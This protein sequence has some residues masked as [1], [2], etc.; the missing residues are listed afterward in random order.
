MV[1]N[2]EKIAFIHINKT[3]GS[4]IET[5]LGRN[6]D[7]PTHSMLSNLKDIKGIDNYYK[8]SFV[9]NPYDKMVSQYF[10]RSQNMNDTRLKGLSFKD[11]VKN[12]DELGFDIK[13]TGNQVAW[14]SNQKWKW[15]TDKKIY[16][17][18]PD[19]IEIGVDFIG[20]FENLHEDW[21]LFQ[22]EVGIDFGE[23][24]HRRKSEHN[25]YQEYYDDET[26]QIVYTRFEDDFKYFDYKF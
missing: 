21:K 23:L 22:K 2:K 11:W 13:G 15:D 10:H 24:P 16:T 4:S 1:L 8:F 3:G 26:R 20:F 18:R 19:N 7:S 25:P 17:Q 14:L 9:R 12:L 6:A 5:A